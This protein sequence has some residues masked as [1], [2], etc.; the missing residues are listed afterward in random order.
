MR[1]SDWM[2][3]G[4]SIGDIFQQEEY[5]CPK[6]GGLGEIEGGVDK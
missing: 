4:K 6:V 3:L 1:I 2:K 5:A